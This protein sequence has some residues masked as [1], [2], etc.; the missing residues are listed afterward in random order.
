V[1]GPEGGDIRGCCHRN[2]KADQG[3]SD[4]REPPRLGCLK[5]PL[6]SPGV[7]EHRQPRGQKGVDGKPRSLP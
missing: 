3:S 5:L 1:D 4:W 7:G 6:T 2:D